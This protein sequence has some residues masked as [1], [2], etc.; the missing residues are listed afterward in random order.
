M[1]DYS[2]IK[3]R[4]KNAKE[5]KGDFVPLIPDGEESATHTLRFVSASIEKSKG[6]NIQAVFKCQVKKRGS[7]LNNKDEN[8][9]YLLEHPNAP[10]Q[11]D[12]FLAVMDGLGL[13]WSRIPEDMEHSGWNDIFYDLGEVSEKID[14]EVEYKYQYFNSGPNKGQKK[15]GYDKRVNFDDIK[16]VKWPAVESDSKDDEGDDEDDTP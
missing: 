12:H 9:Y 13:D 11:L 2:N 16:K 14:F 15:K 4:V 8:I 3:G 5:G 10:W 6:G 7:E 1:P